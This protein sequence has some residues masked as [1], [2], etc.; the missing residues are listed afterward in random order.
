VIQNYAKVQSLSFV[1]DSVIGRSA[2]VGSGAITANRKFNQT[3][4]TVKTND[5]VIDM[6]TDFFGCILGDNSRLGANS[7]TSPGTLIGKYCWIFPLTS[8][9]GFIPEAKRVFHKTPIIMEDNDRIDLA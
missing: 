4:I 6:G 7:V 3:N 5:G 1:G 9:R 2:R 8:V